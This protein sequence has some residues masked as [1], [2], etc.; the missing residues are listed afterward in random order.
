MSVNHK[1]NN[2][3]KEV[4]LVGEKVCS[5]YRTGAAGVMSTDSGGVM[6]VFLE[7]DKLL[8]AFY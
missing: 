4:A 1:H 2:T 3:L 7:V 8:G 6:A 5:I